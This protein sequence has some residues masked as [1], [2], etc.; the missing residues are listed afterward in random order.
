MAVWRLIT[1]HE[2]QERVLSWS[3]RNDRIA[4]GWSHVGDLKKYMSVQAV[5]GEAIRLYP[6]NRNRFQAGEQLWSFANELEKRDLVILSANGGRRAVLEVTGDYEFVPIL[7]EEHGYAHQRVA[8]KAP[9]E[10]NELWKASG[11]AVPGPSIYRALIRCKFDPRD[12]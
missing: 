1:H 6:Q 9:W 4:I 8:V 3:L 7:G 5:Q 10:A 11:G 12:S 2:H